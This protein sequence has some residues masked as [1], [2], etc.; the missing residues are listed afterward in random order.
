[1]GGLYSTPEDVKSAPQ[2]H[3]DQQGKPNADIWSDLF[4][5]DK[6]K[7]PAQPAQQEFRSSI[8]YTQGVTDALNYQL[9]AMESDTILREYG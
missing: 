8:T 5:E 2:T 6:D 9:E 3:Q 7:G 1:M 4:G